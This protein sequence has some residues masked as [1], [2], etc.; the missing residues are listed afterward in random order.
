MRDKGR[1]LVA[2]VKGGLFLSHVIGSR[3]SQHDSVIVSENQR[4]G[5]CQVLHEHWSFVEFENTEG[6]G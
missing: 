3:H 6:P 1:I 5:G 4:R 2:E